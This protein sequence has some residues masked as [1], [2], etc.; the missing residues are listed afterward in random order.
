MTVNRTRA[1]RQLARQLS[2]RS[3]TRVTLDYHDSVH[4]TGR[5]WHIHWTDGPTWRQMLALAAGLGHQSPGID[6]A[7]L[8][9]ARSHTALG[10]AVSVLGWLDADP[11]RV[12]HYPGVW[13]EYACDE[14]AYPERASAQWRHRGQALLALGEGRLEGGALTALETR[15]HAAGWAAALDWL[16]EFGTSGRRLTAI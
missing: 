2:D 16:D 7:Q 8:H 6:V 15:V 1:A 3:H 4:T 13:R 14:I 10:E 5:A 9:P 12:H 11:D